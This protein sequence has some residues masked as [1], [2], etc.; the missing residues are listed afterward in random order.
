AFYRLVPDSA[1]NT[2]HSP[3]QIRQPRKRQRVDSN[4]QKSLKLLLIFFRT[5]AE[6]VRIECRQW[7]T[8]EHRQINP[9]SRYTYKLD[10][11]H[12]TVDPIAF[13]CQKTLSKRYFQLKSHHAI[14]AEYLHCIHKWDNNW[15]NWCNQRKRQTVSVDSYVLLW[16]VPGYGAGP[17]DHPSKSDRPIWP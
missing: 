3:S 7:L 13:R 11:V 17:M 8:K 2:G 12:G 4:V 16:A 14:T 10:F 1:N 5:I 6:R 15:C 9:N